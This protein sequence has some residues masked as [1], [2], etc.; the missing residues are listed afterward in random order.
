MD[1]LRGN[2]PASAVGLYVICRQLS[3]TSAPVSEDSLQKSLQILRPSDPSQSEASAALKHSLN[4]G[5]GLGL[6]ICNERDSTLTLDSEIANGLQDDQNDWPW[7]RAELTHRVMTHALTD[8]ADGVPDLVLGLTWFLQE[9]P[10]SPLSTAWGGGTER[11][12]R[13]LGF[14]AVARS[15]QWLP[16][17]RWALS[18]GF[19]R[20]SDQPNAKVLIPDCSTAISDQLRYLPRASS[21]QEWIKAMHDRIPVAGAKALTD[22]LPEGS[23]NWAS[24]PQSVIFGLL[25]LEATGVLELLPSDD[26]RDVLVIG[27]GASTRQV[28]RISVRSS[29]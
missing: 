24:L 6:V 16:F 15:E 9:S 5:C 28:G 26:A 4:V 2:A 17:Q 19:A 7:F 20:R 29:K 23:N 14:E 22:K 13:D 21:A 12:I 18:L 3:R 10:L 1:Y 11:R 27:L 8:V 25:K